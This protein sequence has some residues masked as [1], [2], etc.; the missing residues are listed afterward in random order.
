MLDS[1]YYQTPFYI[2]EIE[3]RLRTM[4]VEDV[5]RAVRKHLDRWD[6]RVAVVAANATTLAKA[7]ESNAESPVT[8]QTAGTSEEVLAEDET[9]EALALPIG[10]VKI[11]PVGNLFEK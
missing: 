11:V 8:Y 3:Q 9:I 6:F 2:D 1:S 4:K 7:I 5:N 10:T